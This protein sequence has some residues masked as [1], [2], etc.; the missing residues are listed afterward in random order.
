M[1]D[2]I[3]PTLSKLPSFPM[4]D[5]PLDEKSSLVNDAKMGHI[6]GRKRFEDDSRKLRFVFSEMGIRDKIAVDNFAR[7]V[8]NSQAFTF[9]AI[10]DNDEYFNYEFENVK[11]SSLP[12]FKTIGFNLWVISFEIKFVE[13][14][15]SEIP[16]SEDFGFTY[17]LPFWLS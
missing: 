12:E 4:A 15:I 10:A 8:R 11:F 13:V 3:F 6:L 5:M 14:E 2:F 1:S 7:E 17:S 9:P 16:I